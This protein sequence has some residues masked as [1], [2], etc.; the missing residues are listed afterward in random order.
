MRCQT[1][2]N[3]WGS[4]QHQ[5]G[6]EGGRPRALQA[7]E[8]RNYRHC[9]QALRYSHS[10]A[11]QGRRSDSSEGVER[12]SA[13][14]F[15]CQRGIRDDRTATAV[16]IGTVERTRTRECVERPRCAG[17][18]GSDSTPPEIKH[19]SQE[20]AYLDDG[21][22]TN[23]D[24]IDDNIAVAA[25]AAQVKE[26]EAEAEAKSAGDRLE[27]KKRV[28]GGMGAGAS[29][30]TD[31]SPDADIKAAYDGA[32]AQERSVF[33]V[34]VGEQEKRKLVSLGLGVPEA[35]P[36]G[37]RPGASSLSE[38]QTLGQLSLPP[39]LDLKDLKPHDFRE[40]WRE[41]K[42]A[43]LQGTRVWAF[44]EILKWLDDPASPQLFWLKDGRKVGAYG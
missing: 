38:S 3:Q 44:A 11:A 16:F 33:L 40:L 9:H 35:A 23:L 25:Q 27:G 7:Y 22:H 36:Y 41:K 10:C 18:G 20:I 30:L 19:P 31:E 13:A 21:E 34:K 6:P 17:A 5:H 37:L 26:A 4:N 32:S 14:C 43:H 29:A 42:S 1:A 28:R 2:D 12:A 39:T 24:G 8:S 15:C